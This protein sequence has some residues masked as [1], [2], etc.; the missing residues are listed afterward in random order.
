MKRECSTCKFVGVTGKT[1]CIKCK[2]PG[3]TEYKESEE[4]K[5]SHCC[6]GNHDKCLT[7]KE[8]P[9]ICEC[10]QMT[11]KAISKKISVKA[12]FG[13][14]KPTCAIDFRNPKEG[15]CPFLL[16]GKFGT[17]EFCGVTQENIQRE[18][19]GTGFLRPIEGCIVWKGEFE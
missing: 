5:C 2:K 12:F 1:P 3:Y 11:R 7:T 17:Q 16:L 10:N 18:H 14:E 19:G 13:N 8:Y 4:Y 9:C 6:E 15:V